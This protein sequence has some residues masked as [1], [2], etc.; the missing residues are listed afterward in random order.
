MNEK[1]KIGVANLLTFVGAVI[2]IFAIVFGFSDLS[3]NCGTAFFISLFGT[4]LV[5]CGNYLRNGYF[6]FFN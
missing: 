5:Y 4:I 6:K 3:E 1:S 2:V